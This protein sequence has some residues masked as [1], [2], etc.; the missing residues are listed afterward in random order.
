MNKS[1]PGLLEYYVLTYAKKEASIV[2]HAD[3]KVMGVSISSG[4]VN[5]LQHAP[6][7]LDGEE[8]FFR[9]WRFLYLNGAC[10]DEALCQAGAGLH[11]PF[12]P[13]AGAAFPEPFRRQDVRFRDRLCIEKICRKSIPVNTFPQG[14]D[15]FAPYSP[16]EQG[17]TY[18]PEWCE[19]ACNPA[20]PWP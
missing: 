13:D 3:Q 14:Q 5:G 6:V 7:F 8:T 9:L 18:A 15:G 10:V 12:R 2:H 4:N 11:G 19:P 20:V 17:N 1:F 16:Q